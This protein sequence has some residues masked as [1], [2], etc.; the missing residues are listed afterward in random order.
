[1]L[2]AAVPLLDAFFAAIRRMRGRTSVLKG[3]RRHGYDLLATRGW[4]ARA[5]IFAVYAVDAAFATIGCF[6]VR[7]PSRL[8]WISAA[9]GVGLF[10]CVAIRL[11]SL[12][13]NGSNNSAGT[14]D[15]QSMNQEFS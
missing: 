7:N 9:I 6:A 8:L 10:L 4:S 5:T 15:S 14:A 3:D 12:R 2:V 1:L 13:A 11:G